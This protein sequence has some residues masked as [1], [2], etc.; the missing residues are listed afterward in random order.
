MIQFFKIPACL[1][2]HLIQVF[3]PLAHGQT[4]VL[5]RPR[6]STNLDFQ[7]RAVRYLGAIFDL[8]KGFGANLFKE[9]LQSLA[10]VAGICV[11]A[12]NAGAI[13]PCDRNGPGAGMRPGDDQA[14][15]RAVRIHAVAP[16]QRVYE[17][18]RMISA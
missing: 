9:F 6:Q 1:P 12:V 18:P 13:P 14:L 2:C 3:D 11:I 17:L 8:T 7:Q 5:H 16:R 4:Q 10:T 15:K